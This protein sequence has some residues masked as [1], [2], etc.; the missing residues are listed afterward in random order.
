MI[1]LH[2]DLDTEIAMQPS[3]VQHMSVIA[4]PSHDTRM[5]FQVEH[6]YVVSCQGGKPMA[7]AT[8]DYFKTRSGAKRA[9][10]RRRAKL[11][12]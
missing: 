5:P 8:I 6:R 1:P 7:M 3:T 9:E 11:G 2:G 10:A 12:L 4:G